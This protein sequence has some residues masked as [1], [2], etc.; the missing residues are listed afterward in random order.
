MEHAQVVGALQA[1]GR[2][3]DVVAGQADRQRPLLAHQLIEVGTIDV[4][5]DEVNSG[6]RPRWRRRP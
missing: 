6:R 2:L 4:F 3:A 5:E 1:V